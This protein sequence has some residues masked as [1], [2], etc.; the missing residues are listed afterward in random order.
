[1]E[2]TPLVSPCRLGQ[3]FA[4]VSS[5]NRLEYVQTP[6]AHRGNPMIPLF[7]SNGLGD[8]QIDYIP[9]RLLFGT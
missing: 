3:C 8:R 7:D 6:Y 1:V 2:L 4:L 5:I 9:T